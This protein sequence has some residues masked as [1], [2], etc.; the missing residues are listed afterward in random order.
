M[1]RLLILGFLPPSVSC[2]GDNILQP[3]EPE[4]DWSS[5]SVQVKETKIPHLDETLASIDER[6]LKDLQVFHLT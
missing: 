3:F 5:F 2:L 4:M 1:E 6:Q